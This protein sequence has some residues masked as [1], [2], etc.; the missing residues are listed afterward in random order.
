MAIYNCRQCG[1]IIPYAGANC[2]WCQSRREAEKRS[3]N[4]WKG[5]SGSSTSRTYSGGSTSSGRAWGESKPIW[6]VLLAVAAV[7]LA[8]WF[9]RSVF[10]YN[11]YEKSIGE[12]LTAVGEAS[13]SAKEYQDYLLGKDDSYARWSITYFAVKKNFFA[14]LLNLKEKAYYISGKTVDGIHTYSFVF[15]GENLGTKLPDGEYTLTVL[16]GVGVLLDDDKQIIYKAGTEFYDTYAAALKAITHDGIYQFLFEKIGDGEHGIDDTEGLP[17]ELLR[18]ENAAVYQFEEDDYRV[19]AFV[20]EP[21]ENLRHNYSF[22]YAD[23]VSSLDLEGYTYAD[24]VPEI[25]DELG[26][27]LE[28]GSGDSRSYALYQNGEKA[29]SISIDELPNGYEF[30]FYE[31]ADGFEESVP[32]RLNV[33]EK[34]LVKITTNDRYEE[35]RIDMPLSEYQAEYDYLLSIVPE[36]YIRSVIDLDRVEIKKEYLGLVKR[37]QMKDENGN[38]TAEMV[39]A[40]GKIGEVNHYI[41]DTEYVKVEVGY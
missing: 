6:P 10:D 20:E 41:S 5:A 29:V 7:V 4:S 8:G 39:T 36:T 13:R 24:V 19:D 18:G 9:V 1:A 22:S 16:D 26:E 33:N 32:Y 25:N 21:E 37:Y 17:R 27:L 35:V 14:D 11:S 40:F 3:M 23:N 2:A 31:A 38:V 12:E 34:T 15:E 28:K 30:E